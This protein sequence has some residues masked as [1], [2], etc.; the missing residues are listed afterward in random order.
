MKLYNNLENKFVSQAPYNEFQERHVWSYKLKCFGILPGNNLSSQGESLYLLGLGYSVGSFK[1]TLVSPPDC[2]SL[3]VS[4]CNYTPYF[5]KSVQYWLKID[6]LGNFYD[7][8][9]VTD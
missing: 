5:K 9:F 1:N 2:N 6:E 4:S 3:H 7:Q 8:F